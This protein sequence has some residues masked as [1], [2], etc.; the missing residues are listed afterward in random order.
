MEYQKISWIPLGAVCEVTSAGK[1][2]PDLQFFLY[3][4]QGH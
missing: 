3:I 1:G 4:I 2:S